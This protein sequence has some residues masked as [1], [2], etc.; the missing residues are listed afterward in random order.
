MVPLI[1]WSRSTYWAYQVRKRTI[2]KVFINQ[3]FPDS[4]N[5]VHTNTEEY[6]LGDQHVVSP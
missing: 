5:V 6:C 4:L 1:N 2:K 3:L